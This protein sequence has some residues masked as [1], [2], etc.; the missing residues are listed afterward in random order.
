M[1]AA[2]WALATAAKISR[3]MKTINT[4]LKIMAKLDA[5][6]AAAQ[7]ALNAAFF[8]WI[9]IP[10][11]IIAVGVALYLA[12]KR[13]KWF[14]NAVDAVWRW[15]KKNWPLLVAILIG[16]FALAAYYIYHYRDKIEAALWSVVGFFQRIF[17]WVK[18][19]WPYIAIVLLAPFLPGAAALIAIYK[20]FGTIKKWVREAV[21]YI[22]GL[23][24]NLVA[25]FKGLP[26]RIWGALKGVPGHIW[27]TAKGLAH[28]AHVPGTFAGGTVTSAGMTRVGEHGPE[29]LS[30]PMGARV[31]PLTMSGGAGGAGGITHATIPVQVVLNRRVIGEEVAR[32][33]SDERARR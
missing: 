30:L 2:F 15:I 7:W 8:W 25:F 11:L 5:I 18:A 4:E 24:D 19:N 16:P 12:Y 20:F 29:I 10:L 33:V 17:N 21:G 14:H 27:N 6:A 13:V 1:A 26:G 32:W 9:I 28:R 3:T 23:F 31:E 22:K